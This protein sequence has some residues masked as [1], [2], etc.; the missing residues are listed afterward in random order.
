MHEELRCTQ[1]SKISSVAIA[2]IE[3]LCL[4]VKGWY[5]KTCSCQVVFGVLTTQLDGTKCSNK[6]NMFSMNIHRRLKVIPQ[7]AKK[8]SLK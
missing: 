7:W 1:K 5:A 8:F 4:G 3:F 2:D 6:Y